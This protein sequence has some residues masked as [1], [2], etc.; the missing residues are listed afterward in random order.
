MALLEAA[1]AIAVAAMGRVQLAPS[2]L[3]NSGVTLLRARE[4]DQRSLMLRLR[5]VVNAV[6]LLWAL[7]SDDDVMTVLVENDGLDCMVSLMAAIAD[8]LDAGAV[9]R[10]VVLATVSG[11]ESI[12]SAPGFKGRADLDWDRLD[13]YLNRI[14]ARP[15]PDTSLTISRLVGSI[16][17]A[18][19]ALEKIDG[20]VPEALEDWLDLSARAVVSAFQR[21]GAIDGWALRDDAVDLVGRRADPIRTLI[22]M[23]EAPPVE[24][25]RRGPLVAADLLTEDQWTEL[26]QQ[27]TTPPLSS[28]EPV[29]RQV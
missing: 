17:I 12:R 21:L 1:G 4:T 18:I 23:Y 27:I 14:P 20:P 7:L 16:C 15:D 10:S 24:L 26:E 29:L 3:Y 22:D 25:W 8:A 13:T 9:Q 2:R 6:G 5:V 19:G 11:I 28:L